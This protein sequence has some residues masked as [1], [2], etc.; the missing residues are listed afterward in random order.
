MDF[1]ELAFPI[2]VI[3]VF[4]FLF[5]PFFKNTKEIQQNQQEPSNSEVNELSVSNSNVVSSKRIVSDSE[6]YNINRIVDLLPDGIY[7]C[8]QV[9]YNAFMSCKEIKVRNTFNRKMCDALIVDE[10]FYPLLIIEIDG[11]SHQVQRVKE[12]DLQRDKLTA[13]A[14][15]PTLRITNEFSD[16]QLK[17]EIYKYI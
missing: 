12:K 5:F 8:P 11:T 14:G 16:S 17:K 3:I 7:L 6:A 9:S 2:G 4:A 10:N 13:S 15:I 1:L